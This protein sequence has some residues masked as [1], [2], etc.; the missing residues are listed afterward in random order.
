[1]TV[2]VGRMTR[3]SSLMLKQ[4]IGLLLIFVSPHNYCLH[5]GGS[6]L[7][8]DVFLSNLKYFLFRRR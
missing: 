5:L 3:A 6:S 4:L 2:P 1:M 7:L 8:F